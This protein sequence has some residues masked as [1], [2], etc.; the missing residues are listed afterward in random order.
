[1]PIGSLV[2]TFGVASDKLLA[3]TQDPAANSP[4]VWTGPGSH[5]THSGHTTGRRVCEGRTGP[6]KKRVSFHGRF[7]RLG[8]FW[9]QNR[10]SLRK[11][12]RNVLVE[13]PSVSN[14]VQASEN[15]R[16]NFVLN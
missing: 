3:L 8:N 1:M 10:A 14:G 6:R 11:A 4:A 2:P 15:R 16:K 9:L 13:I 12:A 5:T 7:L